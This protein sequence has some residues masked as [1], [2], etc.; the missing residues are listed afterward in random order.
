MGHRY[1]QGYVFARPL[2]VAQLA[3]GAWDVGTGLRD[4]VATLPGAAS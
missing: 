4:V 3:A 2:E 1:L